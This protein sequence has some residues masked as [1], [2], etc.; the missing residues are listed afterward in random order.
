RP[1]MLDELGLI[2]ALRSY[3]REFARRTGL[4]V[5]FKA[6]PDAES[7]VGDRKLVLFRVAQ[8]SLT[9]VAKHAGA[10]RVDVTLRKVDG[11]ICME[12]VDDGKSFSEDALDHARRKQRLGLLGM[13]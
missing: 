1:S 3:L 10:S 2:P 12:I 5:Q 6:T 4:R 9:N 7:F 8:E 11:A 13:Q